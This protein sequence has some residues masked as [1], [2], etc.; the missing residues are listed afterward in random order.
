MTLQDVIDQLAGSELSNVFTFDDDA[1]R[2]GV[3]SVGKLIP[4]LNL[5]L[6]L[7]HNRFF[8]KEGTEIINMQEGVWTYSLTNPDVL[9]IEAVKDLNDNE[10]L[11]DVVGDPESLIRKNLTTLKV[12]KDMEPVTLEVTYRAGPTKLIAMDRY[13]IPSDVAVDLPD[14]FMEP[15]VLFIGSR[16]LNPMGASEG[17]HEGNNYAAK[18][19]QACR[20]LE[21][22]NYDLD[23]TDNTHSFE[24]A[25]WV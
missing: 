22:Q 10:Y 18:Y 1:Q 23:R 9:R 2:I 11:L 24:T 5:G 13:E 7:L 20:L 21:N 4:Q 15:L 3:E 25:G 19:E 6:Q 14:A 12:P 17:M 8:L 16:F